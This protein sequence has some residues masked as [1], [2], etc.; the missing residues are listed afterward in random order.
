MMRPKNRSFLDDDGARWT[1]R[2]GGRVTD[3]QD[4]ERYAARWTGRVVGKMTD[5]QDMERYAAGVHSQTP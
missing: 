5:H 1:G 4:M 2:D 3:R